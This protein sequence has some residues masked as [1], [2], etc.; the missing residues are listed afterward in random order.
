MTHRPEYIA[1]DMQK[2]L[3]SLGVI[4]VLLGLLWPYIQK[5]GLG[6]LPGDIAVERE[7]FN[8]YFPLTTSIIISIV[9]SLV[10]WFFMRK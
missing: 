10:V 3:I 6:R 7:G 5:L 4:L 8:F 2:F 9:L 1:E